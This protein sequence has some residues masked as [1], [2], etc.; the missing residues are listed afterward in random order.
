[1]N[2]VSNR[3]MPIHQKVHRG[4]I[5]LRREHIVQKKTKTRKKETQARPQASFMKDLFTPNG[6][7]IVPCKTPSLGK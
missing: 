6:G 2:T 4:Y 1:M 3:N 5:A 7:K